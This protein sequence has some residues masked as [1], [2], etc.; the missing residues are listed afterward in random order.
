MRSR[1]P[2]T[3]LGQAD[4]VSDLNPVRKKA[5]AQYGYPLAGNKAGTRANDRLM[6]LTYG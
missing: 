4:P 1:I 6:R 2:A 3:F 5:R